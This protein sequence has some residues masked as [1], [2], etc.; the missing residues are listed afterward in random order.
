MRKLLVLFLGLLMAFAQLPAQEF[1]HE[2]AREIAPGAEHVWLQKGHRLP[3]FVRFSDNQRIELTAIDNYIARTFNLVAGVDSWELIN[4]EKDNLGHQ[5]DRYQQ[6]Y[7]G[8]PVEGS[9]LIVHSQ[10]GMVYSFNGDFYAMSQAIASQPLVEEAIALDAAI[11]DMDASLY[12]WEIPGEESFLQRRHAENPV[13]YP[14]T[15]YYPTGELVIVP[16]NGDFEEA[17]FRLSWKFDVYAQ[18]PIRRADMF[19]DAQ[20][21]DVICEFNKI[22]TADSAGTADTR[23]SGTRDII[24]DN[25]MGGFRLRESGR[26]NGILTFNMQNG[27]DYNN[28][29]DFVDNDNDWDFAGGAPLDN[30]AADAHWGSE[31]TYDYYLQE[32]GRNSIDGN[33]FALESYINYDQG[34]ANAFWDGQRMTYGDGGTRPF[35]AIDISSH[36]VT[37]GLTSRTSNLIYQ[38]ESG[39][40]NE[41]FS[42]I[43]GKAVENFGRPNNFSWSIGADIGAFRDMSDP[44]RFGDPANY[45]G[46]SWFT[47]TGDNGGVHINSGVQNHWFYL[48]VEGGQGTN[49]FNEAYDVPQI[50][51]DTAAAVA[52]RNNTVYLTRSSQYEDARFYAIQSA[53]DLYGTCS[54]PHEAVVDAWHA[55]GIG[56]PFSY[57]PVSDFTSLSQIV[58]SKPYEVE[59]TDNSLSADTY[60]WNF[61]D[62]DTS[63]VASPSHVYITPGTYSVELQITGICG[64]ADTVIKS[65]FITVNQAPDAPT[66]SGASTIPCRGRATL[67]GT[68]S[69][70]VHWYDDQ[71]VLLEINNTFQTPELNRTSTFYARNID[72]G[73]SQLVGPP[74]NAIGGGGYFNAATEARL[75]F[76]VYRT[77]RLT[78]A[79][80]NANGAGVRDIVLEDRNGN[81]LETVSVNLPAGPSLADLNIE[82]SPGRYQIGG[83][84]L[85]LY[86]NNGGARYPYEIPGVLSITGSSAGGNFYYFL[87][88]WEVNEVCTSEP[89]PVTVNVTPLNDPTTGDATRCGV[90]Q[91]TLT[92]SHPQGDINWY[93]TNG[94][95]VGRGNTFTTPV[96]GASR[97]YFAEAEVGP[98]STN[99][100]P[101][102]PQAVGAGGYFDRGTYRGNIF[103]VQKPI[104]IR[105]ALVDAGSAGPRTVDVEDA[106][107]N[108][109]QSV[110]INVPAGQ[111]RVILDI[112]LA[113]GTYTIGG[114]NM[115]LFRNNG[116]AV[117]PYSFPGLVSITGS[118][119]NA[120]G[121]YYFFYDLEIQ[122]APCY[123]NRVPVQA[124]ISAGTGPNAQFAFTQSGPFVQFNNQSSASA[125]SYFWDFGDGN[126]STAQ[127]P[128]HTY[129]ATGQYTV[130][131]VI[132]DGTCSESTTQMV[133]VD[134]NVGVDP[135]DEID[136]RLFPN[137]GNGS[138]I[139]SA[140]LPSAQAI[141]IDVYDA[142]GRRV[143]NRTISTTQSLSTEVNLGDLPSGTYYVRLKTESQVWTS[144]YLLK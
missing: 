112:D 108:L 66:V 65:N 99:F 94:N 130:V 55:V 34:F 80:V 41:S 89:I 121:F 95:L 132:D 127:N 40:L 28:A 105:S 39:A 136:L 27:T 57:V 6:L 1:H 71:D 21:G 90:G 29:V 123:S 14:Q 20:R 24:A 139:V 30:A 2:Q 110:Q 107:G 103:Q 143:F 78:S 15:T 9:M 68:A 64:G 35:T 113:P 11:N 49:D 48:L 61:G 87:Y 124:I 36:E 73:L 115:D 101:L 144:K 32:H 52:F 47:G 97:D 138:F 111:S 120:D 60:T 104:R 69:N 92:A 118:N 91:V 56:R 44:N 42:D 45:L 74:N 10:N 93:D 126:T 129:T 37:H 38:N 50:G 72:L 122:E 62:G 81:V 85:D 67:Q 8:Y 142:L 5:H 116:S 141:G 19:V 33:G 84:N 128:S 140:T 125:T 17:D 96:L 134:V 117:Y 46:L 76:E 58:C 26:G 102:T 51:W 63:S 133:E 43:F 3:K 82:L 23:Y 83:E 7:R 98:A 88:N 86:R 59:F 135:S 131:L 119:A 54:R 12:K 75:E 79:W 18:V 16:V 53:I 137:P 109:V 100:G 4:S 106:Q 25:F 22:H 114:V 31:M 13:A 70:T 77:C